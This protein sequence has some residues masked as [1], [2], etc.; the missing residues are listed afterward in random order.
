MGEIHVLIIDDST[1]GLDVLKE[2]L[3][4]I[5]VSA[6]TVQ[7]PAKVDETIAGLDRID[8]VFL[9]L[10]MPQIDGYGMLQK[11]R[12]W[13]ITAPIIAYTVHTNEMDTAKKLG[14]DG[15]LG[16]PVDIDHFPEQFERIVN[17]GTVWEIGS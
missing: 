14:F 9:D 1:T 5:G 6:T 10:E 13:G 17:G 4:S 11:L 8:V 12:D 3:H 16:K 2:L 15:F 7:Q